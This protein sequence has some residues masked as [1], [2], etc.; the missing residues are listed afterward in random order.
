ML[1]NAYDGRDVGKYDVPG[2][3]L[4]ARLAPRDDNERVLMKLRG[5]FV[6]TMCKVNPEHTKNLIYEKGQ[7]VLYMEILQAKYGCVESPL[8][9]YKLYSETLQKE[10]FIR[11]PYDRCVANKMIDGKQRLVVWYVDDNKVSHKDPKNVTKVIDLTKE[12]FGY[13]KVTRGN[14]HRFLGMNITINKE[15]SIE[16]ETEGQLLNVIEMFVLAEGQDV[17]KIVTSPAQKNLREVNPDCK[18]LSPDKADLFHSIVA[19]L[20]WIIK[21]SRPDLE[22]AVSF[23]C[24]RVS[25]SDEDDWKNLRRVIAFAKATIGDVRI[26][27]ADDLTNKVTWIDIAYAVSADTKSQTG[28]AMSLGVGVLHC[29]ST[30]QKLNVKSSTEAELV[31]ASDYMPYNI[32]LLMFHL[33]F[34]NTRCFFCLLFVIM[35]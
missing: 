7:K 2:A 31:G 21:R 35:A 23:L 3:Y 16:I 19:K 10:G 9:W 8:R 26:I 13:L 32:W 29:K 22:T 33:C 18:P 17:E 12:H 1:I 28:G 20:L 4:Q 15:K 30:K 34:N 6:D 25:K 11:N 5:K 27:G 24:T 14:K